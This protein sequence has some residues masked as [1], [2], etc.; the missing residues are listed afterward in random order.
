[1]TDFEGVVPTLGAA[2]T[3][4][5]YD[6][7]TPVQEAVIAPDLADRDLL[8]SAQTGSGKTVAFGIALG[9]TL[10]GDAERFSYA[11]TPLALVVAPTRELALQVKRELEWLYAGAGASVAS[12]VGGMD[13]R[14]ERRALERG[15]HIVVGTPGRLRDHIARNSLDMS[16]LRA[17]VLDEADEMLDMGFR[18]DLEFILGVAP[19]TRRTL[20]F[21]AT[22]PRSIASL[23]TRYQRDAARVTTKAER[24]QHVDIEYRA[25]NV[26]PS[27][28]ENAII[29]V[30]RY[31][32]PTNALV[33][34]ST[35]AAVNR[36]MSRF[37]NRGFAVV[38]L[39]GELSQNERSHAL[40]ALRDGRAQVC[41][42]TDVAAR[43]LDLPNLELV[44]H[45][46]IPKN[47]E[48][49]LHRS[50][51][52][53][54][55]GR[56]GVCALIVP[57]SERRRTERLLDRAN[58][59]A[60]WG[61][62]PSVEEIQ[63]RDRLR[64]LENP[65][66]VDPITDDEMAFVTEIL[67]RHNPEQVAAAFLRAH[68]SGQSAPEELIDPDVRAPKKN[69]RED[70]T[71]GVWFSISVGRNDNAE[72]RWLLPMLCRVGQI[73]GQD[74]GSIKIQSDETSFEIASGVSDKFLE[75]VGP[76]MKL[77]K[78]V[79]LTRLDGPPAGAQRGDKRGGAES[80]GPRKPY[81]KKPYE[82][83]PCAKK[84]YEK[85]P[86]EKKPYAK[87]AADRIKQSDAP[88]PAWA[89]KK[90]NVKPV[91]DRVKRD[92][93]P[94]PERATDAGSKPKPSKPYVKKDRPAETAQADFGF[95]A[96][97]KSADRP[98]KPKR[99]PDAASITSA[100][101]RGAEKRKKYKGKSD[102]PKRPSG[103]AKKLELADKPGKKPAYQYDQQTTTGR[104]KDG[105]TEEGGFAVLKRKKPRA[106]KR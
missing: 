77:E 81:E 10:L 84:P 12:C 104:R 37:T 48:S 9:P 22:V 47:P 35:R 70:F 105:K 29:N 58:I 44:I 23:A 26:A 98:R 36:M 46:D 64:L 3:A 33:F 28:R 32:N 65:Q 62:P 50:G 90:P 83:K 45:A 76:D 2:L 13:M 18:D 30:L 71:N 31:F 88:R 8:V 101:G 93:A 5:G 24:E 55:A 15:A 51:R 73:T 89:E 68:A 100:P 41:I 6:T 4:R 34:C 103:P 39:S 99:K 60:E 1:M 49:L 61:R 69:R 56:K 20:M 7:L 38:A 85:K 53:G 21:S 66:L 67:E 78:N 63:Q 87:P 25:M 97:G 74:I 72:P 94:R 17:A 57:H 59:T 54:R 95:D 19:E 80:R 11:A 16:D 14:M 42:A 106:K 91:E 43:G 40:Q 96:P 75:A 27:D 52:T 79:S 86:Y 92:A 102:A 82:K